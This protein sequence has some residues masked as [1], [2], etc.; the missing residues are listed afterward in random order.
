M[1]MLGK[2]YKKKETK[3]YFLYKRYIIGALYS[4]KP[5]KWLGLVFWAEAVHQMGYCKKVF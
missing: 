4:L 3:H 1:S 2:K 5:V